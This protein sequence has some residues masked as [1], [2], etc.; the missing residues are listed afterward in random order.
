[1]KLDKIEKQIKDEL[2]HYRSVSKT[3]KK[4]IENVIQ[5]TK[6]KKSITL[7]LDQQDLNQIR[8][9]AELEGVP[10]QTLISSI[11][12]KYITDQLVD[13]KE[14]AKS[15]RIIRDAESRRY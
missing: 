11:L 13:Q 3:A 14:I 9:R 8:N 2:D 7:Q 15:I 1:M 6:Q 4:K 5:K 12:H 10:Y